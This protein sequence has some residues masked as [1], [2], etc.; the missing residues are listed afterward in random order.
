MKKYMLPAAALFFGLTGYAVADGYDLTVK[1][2]G[3]LA[4]Y[5]GAA[6]SGDYITMYDASADKFVKIDPRTQT[7]T[8]V[9]TTAGNFAGTV[10]LNDDS[11]ASP[12][13][14]LQDGTDETATFSKADAD[15]LSLT[16]DAT[17]GLN[18]LTGNLKVGN[19]TP[20][21]T[22]NG[23]DAYVEGTFE[24]DGAQQYD[25]AAVFNSTV[26]L[27]T[28]VTQTRAPSADSATT[29]KGIAVN[30]T[31]PVDTTGTNTHNG[32]DVGLTISNATGGTNKV[33]A[34]NVGNVTGD[35]QD[36]VTGL[37]IGTGT[38]LGTS[39][40]VVIGSGWDNG[41][42]TDSGVQINS[43]NGTAVTALRFAFDT[44]ASGQTAKTTTLTGVTSSSRCVASPNE[45]PTNVGYIKSV[46]PGTDQVVITVNTDP[47]ASNLDFTVICLN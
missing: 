41:L 29:N 20:G 30:L 15:F 38:T 28:T 24:V 12:S 46:A 4:V 11:G 39:N 33:N 8:T 25:G 21:V 16:T 2:I 23:E 47:G 36:D 10:T 3:E 5:S 37:R 6:A 1:S 13:L 22:L 26:A 40:A 9:N 17:D 18:I 32:V 7:F 45:I 19:G 43:T 44:V 27:A 14:I 31:A 34:L 42:V 35:A